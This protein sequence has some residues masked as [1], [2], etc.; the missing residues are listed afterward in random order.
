MKLADQ[1]ALQELALKQQ[2]QEQEKNNELETT[3][4]DEE[5]EDLYRIASQEINGLKIAT[6]SYKNV[7]K[8]CFYSE[9][10]FDETLTN[11]F[12]ETIEKLLIKLLPA[13]LEGNY[14][15]IFE[16]LGGQITEESFNNLRIGIYNSLKEKYMRED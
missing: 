9:F 8:N 5:L 15:I 4:T 11:I 7:L 10:I 6:T 3:I 12:F 2:Q 1:K 16:E 14:D 13:I